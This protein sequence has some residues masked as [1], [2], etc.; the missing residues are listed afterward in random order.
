MCKY[1]KRR[2]D[3]GEESSEEGKNGIKEFGMRRT[4]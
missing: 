2:R 3:D 1:D 4:Q